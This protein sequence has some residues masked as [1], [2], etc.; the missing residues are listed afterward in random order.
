M[1][2]RSYRCV[3]LLFFL[4]MLQKAFL[5][6]QAK[7]KK[8]KVRIFQTHQCSLKKITASPLS[9]KKPRHLTPLFNLTFFQINQDRGYSEMQ[10]LAEE[11][12]TLRNRLRDVVHSPLSDN[13]K[14]QIID[15]SQRLHS[16]AP[17]SIAM[18]NVMFL[19]SYSSAALHHLSHTRTR[20]PRVC[21]AAVCFV[22]FVRVPTK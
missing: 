14:Q 3:F 21:C 2:L 10:K 13:E 5:Q 15:D 11:N 6:T 18:P 8:R 1:R 9:N 16:S 22:Q 17:A 19:P 12:Q 7:N 20:F 4:R